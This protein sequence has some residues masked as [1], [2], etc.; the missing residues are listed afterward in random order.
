MFGPEMEKIMD[1]KEEP[2]RTFTDE[3]RTIFENL[4]KTAEATR[5][6]T[7]GVNADPVVPGS[8]E[9]KENSSGADKIGDERGRS[10]G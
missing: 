4:D 10:T 2:T 5:P 7:P 6:M 8:A 1:E 9:E 3:Q